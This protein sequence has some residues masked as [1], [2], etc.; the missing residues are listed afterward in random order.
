MKDG[1]KGKITAS[2]PTVEL[3][4]VMLLDSGHVQEMDAEWRTRKNR[5]QARRDVPP[6]YTAKDAEDPSS[7]WFR[8]NF[9]PKSLL[10]LNRR[11]GSTQKCRAYLG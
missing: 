11:E 4:E 6:L 2:P 10:S 8:L 3:C 5:R 9:S 1:F 7:T